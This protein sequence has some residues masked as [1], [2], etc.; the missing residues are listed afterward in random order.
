MPRFS[1]PNRSPVRSRPGSSMKSA[2]LGNAYNPNQPIQV[3]NPTLQTPV[4][5]QGSGR[6]PVRKNGAEDMT[7]STTQMGESGKVEI[8]NIKVENLYKKTQTEIKKQSTKSR[9]QTSPM[10]FGRSLTRMSSPVLKVSSNRLEKRANS[11]QILRYGR[12]LTN[13][14]QN[15]QNP[16][17]LRKNIIHQENFLKSS[18]V[19]DNIQFDGNFNQNGE[20]TNID[21]ILQK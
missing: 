6:S 14:T 16:R 13:S 5:K 2:T 18:L 1:S 8:S 7:V 19:N 11:K 21:D 12:T 20:L 17:A 15:L 9:I 3:Y 4:H 10:K